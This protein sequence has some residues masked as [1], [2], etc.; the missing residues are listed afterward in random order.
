MVIWRAWGTALG[1]LQFLG[2]RGI[3]SAATAYKKGSAITGASPAEAIAGLV[4]S[5]TVLVDVWQSAEAFEGVSGVS[6]AWEEV[7]SEAKS[8]ANKISSAA[9]EEQQEKVQ[10]WI[11]LRKWVGAN[12]ILER[13]RGKIK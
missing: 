10:E 5:V 7:I 6:S 1:L 11:H 9:K 2:E 3:D 13:S 4:D 12:I 8:I